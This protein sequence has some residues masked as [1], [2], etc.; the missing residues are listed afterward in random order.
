MQTVLGT[1]H[2]ALSISS[3]S[4]ASQELEEGKRLLHANCAGPQVLL[5]SSDGSCQSEKAA[6]KQS[7]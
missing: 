2:I 4:T 1:P 6:H 7:R 3:A 5:F